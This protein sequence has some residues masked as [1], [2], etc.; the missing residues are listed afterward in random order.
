MAWLLDT[1]VVSEMM[2]PH[3]EP[4]VAR[5]LD[6]VANEGLHVSAVTVWEILNGIGQLDPGA[7][8]EDP[9]R[10]FLDMLNGVFE[11]RVLAWTAAD[12]AQCARIMEEKRMRGEPL[13]HHLPD[14]MLAGAAASRGLAV[15]TLNQRDFRNTGNPARVAS[16]RL[17]GYEKRRLAEEDFNDDTKDAGEL[18]AGHRGGQ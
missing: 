2:R 3:P 9:S 16:Y 4:R 10:R 7:R 6:G 1:N 14:A 15:V 12:A 8:R 13:D 18:G 11:D 17:I 5:F